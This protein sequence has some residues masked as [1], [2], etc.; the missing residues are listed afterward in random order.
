MLVLSFCTL[1]LS[2]LGGGPDCALPLA[3]FVTGG[4]Q[5][6]TG[7]RM[8]VDPRTE[9]TESE[10]RLAGITDVAASQ[11]HVSVAQG[12]NDSIPKPCTSSTGS[13][14]PSMTPCVFATLPAMADA[15]MD[16]GLV[17]EEHILLSVLAPP[18][19][20]ISPDLPPPRA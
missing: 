1:Q 3:G 2:L 18:S 4:T 11:Y 6:M 13:D 17:R 8:Q 20:S 5:D 15:S 19:T 7:M 12:D 14:C 9:L 10:E 16:M